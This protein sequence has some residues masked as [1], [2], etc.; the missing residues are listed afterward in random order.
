MENRPV[1]PTRRHCGIDRLHTTI[2]AQDEI[3]HIEAQAKAIGHGDL[4]IELVELKL[5][6]GLIGIVSEV[7]HIA[8]ID[9]GGAVEFLE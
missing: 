8:G 5:T 6:S 2:D 3:V 9:K 1:P 4:P 7:P